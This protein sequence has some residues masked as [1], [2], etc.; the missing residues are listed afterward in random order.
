MKK[1]SFYNRLKTGLG[2]TKDKFLDGLESLKKLNQKIDDE[3][4]DELEELLISADM[5]VGTV[6]SIVDDLRDEAKKTKLTE[7]SEVEQLLKSKMVERMMIDVPTESFPKVILLVGVNGAGK[8]TTAGKIA[9]YYRD[10]NKSVTLAAADTFRAAASN[11]LKVWAERTGVGFIGSV[12]GADPS[13]VLYDAIDSATAKH[14]DVLICDTAGRLHNKKNLMNE[15]EKMNRVIDKKYPQA[16]K[17]V[18]LVIDAVTGLNALSQAE[19][20]NEAAGLDGVV[21][22]KLDGTAKGG[23]AVALCDRLKKPIKFIGVGEKIED[24]NTFD[25]KDFIDALFER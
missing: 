19:L 2:K 17:E 13:S 14:T 18:L 24:L 10:K 5:G 20:F 3:F 6:V 23:I 7:A 25:P 9:A 1:E 15:L 16:S 8:T 4:F 11:Q 12:E 21:L 22:T